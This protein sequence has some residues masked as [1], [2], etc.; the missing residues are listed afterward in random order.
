MKWLKKF[1]MGACVTG[2]IFGIVSNAACAMSLTN[3]T[4]D[5]RN[6]T[7]STL[8]ADP[9]TQSGVMSEGVVLNTPVQVWIS[10]KF[11][12]NCR[13]APIP[14]ISLEILFFRGVDAFTMG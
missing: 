2:F 6:A 14:L 1:F 11:P 10:V 13:Q 12:S 9:L 3:M 4:F 7:G 5:A 8:L